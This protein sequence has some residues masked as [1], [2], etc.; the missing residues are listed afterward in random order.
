MLELRACLTI[1]YP[2]QRLGSLPSRISKGSSRP[3]TS[4]WESS[5]PF[6][7]VGRQPQC[8]NHDQASRCN[9]PC[10]SLSSHARLH[11]LLCR[12]PNGRLVDTCG[13]TM[14]NLWANEDPVSSSLLCEI[15]SMW[16]ESKMN[17]SC[18]IYCSVHDRYAIVPADR[19]LPN[20]CDR[21]VC[22]QI[23]LGP[24][25]IRCH[26]YYAGINETA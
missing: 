25:Q 6:L 24:S 10:I 1:T 26:R 17:A 19:Q 11:I 12:N 4:L 23:R 2:T 8:E 5:I 22:L 15:S 9:L 14:R 3:A 18:R 21:L 16:A 7:E 20:S 13:R